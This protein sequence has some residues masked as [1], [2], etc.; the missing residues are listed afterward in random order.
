MG[1]CAERKKERWHPSNTLR[2][3]RCD[4]AAEKGGGWQKE[5]GGDLNLHLS[6]LKN[7]NQGHTVSLDL[8]DERGSN[9]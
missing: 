9:A 3:E 5:A 8:T 7:N 1:V 4:N 2:S 6:A